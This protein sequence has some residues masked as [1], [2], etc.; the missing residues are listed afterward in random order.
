MPS[1]WTKRA[2]RCLAS[3]LIT[4]TASF[5]GFQTTTLAHCVAT[6]CQRTIQCMKKNGSRGSA[7]CPKTPLNHVQYRILTSKTYYKEES[8]LRSHK[9]RK[10]LEKSTRSIDLHHP[11]ECSHSE[12]QIC[13]IQ[14]IL[15][16]KIKFNSLAR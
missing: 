14:S 8:P 16:S 12:N 6:S 1:C 3:T 13:T 2:L 11:P 9:K 15:H 10:N 7:S 5:R 4:V